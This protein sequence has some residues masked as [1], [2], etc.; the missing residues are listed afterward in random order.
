MLKPNL[1][2]L[3]DTEGSTIPAGFPRV[4]DAHVHIFPDSLFQAI[5]RWFDAGLMKIS[6]EKR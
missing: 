3:N 4:I 6:L 1:P 5:R 2:S